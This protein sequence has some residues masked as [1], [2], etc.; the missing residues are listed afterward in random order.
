[1]ET[2]R[3]QALNIKAGDIVVDIG[4]GEGRHSIATSAY[5]PDATCI[6]LDLC[7]EDLDNANKKTQTFFSKNNAV[8]YVNAN[9]YTLPF[10][11]GSIDH[12]ICSEVLEHIPNYQ[13]VLHEIDRTLKDGGSFSTSVPRAWPE[14]ICWYF[15]NEYHQ[16]DGGHIRIFDA[17]ALK[18]EISSLQFSYLSR[19]WAHALHAPYWWLRCIF[20]RKNK[21]HKIVELYHRILV[22]DL[23]QRPWLTQTL[24]RLLNPI[25]GKSIVMYFRKE[26]M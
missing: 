19:H 4:C 9:A 12:V 20:W 13:Q 8:H 18:S 14:K 23:M 7:F 11:D 10:A 21:Q 22:W 25:M 1:L 3:T 16:V 2:I 15:S 5:F 17:N 26:K 24:E 6:G